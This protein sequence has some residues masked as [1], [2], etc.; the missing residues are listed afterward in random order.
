MVIVYQ[1]TTEKAENKEEHLEKCE[2]QLIN[3][4]EKMVYKERISKTRV[5]RKRRPRNENT[6]RKKD[7]IRKKKGTK[8]RKRN[9]KRG[10]IGGRAVWSTWKSE[11]RRKHKKSDKTFDVHE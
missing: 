1:E 11:P 5:M 4:D 3:L 9:K 10:S 8:A 6:Q 7:K 2:E